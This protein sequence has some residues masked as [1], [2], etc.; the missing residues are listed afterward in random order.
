[1]HAYLNYPKYEELP[2]AIALVYKQQVDICESTCLEENACAA[3][4]SE[5]VSS[6]TA[7][8]HMFSLRALCV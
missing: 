3:K 6:Q 8:L 1:M 5:D 4:S 2:N 7:W